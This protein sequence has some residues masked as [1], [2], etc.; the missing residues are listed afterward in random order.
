MA[1]ALK[2][3][4]VHT[5]QSFVRPSVRLKGHPDTRA[6]IEKMMP[7]FP[8]SCMVIGG[9]LDDADQFWKVNYHWELLSQ[10]VDMAAKLKLGSTSSESLKT[11]RKSLDANRPDPLTGYVTSKVVG[12]PHDRS[13]AADVVGRW[14]RLRESK[15][16]FRKVLDTEKIPEKYKPSEAWDLAAAPLAK[17]GTSK[18]G[19]GYAFDIH[20]DNVLIKSIC[21]GLGATLVFDEKSHVHVEFKQGILVGR[22]HTAD[23]WHDG[24][25]SGWMHGQ[26][27]A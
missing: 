1:A 10:R 2:T 14:Q 17:P 6:M 24:K 21:S 19:T 13:S 25:W 15:Q 27:V 3:Y 8:K 22:A 20:G 7:Y 5:W 16:A 4:S 11:I 23:D 26:Q 12:Q 18:H 9:Y